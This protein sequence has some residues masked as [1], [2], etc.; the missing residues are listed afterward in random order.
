LEDNTP[1]FADEV[2]YALLEFQSE[3]ESVI[4]RSRRLPPLTAITFKA[5][6]ELKGSSRKRVIAMIELNKVLRRLDAEKIDS[7][8]K[9]IRERVGFT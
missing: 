4:E 5:G 3:L 8:C 9:I 2:R 1:F 6:L 7:I